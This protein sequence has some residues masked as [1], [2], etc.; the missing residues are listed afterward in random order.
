[1]TF[2][3]HFPNRVSILAS[4]WINMLHRNG[5]LVFG[6]FVVKHHVGSI[7]LSRLLDKYS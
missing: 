4:P 6:T 5:V 2:V 7:A 1:D 3:Y